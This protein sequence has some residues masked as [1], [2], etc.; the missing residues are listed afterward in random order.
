MD[1]YEYDSIIDPTDSILDLQYILGKT[2]IHDM[3]CVILSHPL[4]IH[5][6]NKFG[7]L[8]HTCNPSPPT[9]IIT[10]TTITV[11][12]HQSSNHQFFI[13]NQSILQAI[14]ISPKIKNIEIRCQTYS[15]HIPQI[16]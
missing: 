8:R 11:A 7:M 12:N 15:T 2:T 16:Y 9:T 4:N 10:S 14:I 3:Y 5:A 1:N 6:K 13:S